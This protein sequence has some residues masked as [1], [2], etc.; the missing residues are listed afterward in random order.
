MIKIIMECFL[1]K[2]YTKLTTCTKLED[3]NDNDNDDDNDKKM[4]FKIPTPLPLL[5]DMRFPSR[6]Q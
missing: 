1:L 2:S 4:I 5:T 6:V 3:N